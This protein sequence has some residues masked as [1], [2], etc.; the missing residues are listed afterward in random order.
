MIISLDQMV[1]KVLS[2]K[3]KYRIAVAWPQDVNTISALKRAVNDGF[4][5]AVLIGSGN[6]IIRICHSLG[7]NDEVFM[8]IDSET[9]ESAARD[10]AY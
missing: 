8:V 3:E 7:I 10:A 6:E 2:T 5:E 4:A 9:E 1:Q